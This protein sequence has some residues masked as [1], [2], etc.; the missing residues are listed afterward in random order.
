[1]PWGEF[2]TLLVGLN[3]ETP[4]GATVA[5][6]AEKDPKVIKTWNKDK[7]KI[8]ADWQRRQAKQVTREE[9]E[10]AMKGLS[11]AF[12]GMAK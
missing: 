5:I 8:R 2:E 11:A 3:E 6:R 12:R 7:K 10:A 4:L 1:M 9:Y